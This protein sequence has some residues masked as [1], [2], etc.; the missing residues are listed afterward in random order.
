MAFGTFITIAV[1]ASIAVYGKA[2]AE[3]LAGRHTQGLFWLGTG[4]RLVAGALIA[5]FGVVMTLAALQ[6]PVSGG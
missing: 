5:A 2:L 1:V 6:G 4:L 3:R